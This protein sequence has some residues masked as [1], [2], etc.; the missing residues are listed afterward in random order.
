MKK[1]LL[2]MGLAATAWCVQSSAQ[3]GKM[4]MYKCLDPS[5]KVYYSDKMNPECAN[6]S[7]MNRQGVVM[8]KKPQVAKPGQPGQPGAEPVQTAAQLEKSRRDRALMATYTNDEEI[9]AAR[10]RSLAMSEQG[11]KTLEVKLEKSNRQL[12]DLKQK[13]DTIAA[14]KKPL[15]P[16]LLEDVGTTQKELSGL[17][18]EMAQRKAQSEAIRVKFDA[19]KQRFRELGGRTTQASK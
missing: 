5:G 12:S 10:D 18:A 15:P 7:E 2:V 1:L 11:V 9:D 6:G 3:D 17:Q 4:R 19:D 8:P 16:Q 13:A 14:Q